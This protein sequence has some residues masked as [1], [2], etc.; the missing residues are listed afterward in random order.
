MAL[1]TRISLPERNIIP[2]DRLTYEQ[3]CFLRGKIVGKI[4]PNIFLAYFFKFNQLNKNVVFV[5]IFVNEKEII[6][7]SEYYKNSADF[8][9][10][11]PSFINFEPFLF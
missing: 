10:S 2:P 11:L 3:L 4:S 7:Q 1:Q 8:C 9:L 5:T 6:K